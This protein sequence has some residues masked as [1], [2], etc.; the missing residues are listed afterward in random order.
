MP[1][2][3]F[4]G[5]GHNWIYFPH[6]GLCYH[7]VVEFPKTYYDALEFCKRRI[8]GLSIKVVDIIG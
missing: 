8:E 6:T 2:D 5:C 1:Y 3:I 7:Y 4:S